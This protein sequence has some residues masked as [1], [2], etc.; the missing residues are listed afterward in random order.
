MQI[1]KEKVHRC[2]IARICT[3]QWW[4]C[5]EASQVWICHRVDGDH[6][7][8]HSHN[9]LGPLDVPFGHATEIRAA[10]NLSENYVL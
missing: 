2:I 1:T 4:V 5:G 3:I 10:R 7:S 8:A 6:A 9:D